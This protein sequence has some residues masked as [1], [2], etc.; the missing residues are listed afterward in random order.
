MFARLIKVNA[1]LISK[2]ANKTCYV[3]VPNEEYWH[4][5]IVVVFKNETATNII[6][7]A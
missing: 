6:N 1:N 2:T 5:H 4:L 3:D 7:V